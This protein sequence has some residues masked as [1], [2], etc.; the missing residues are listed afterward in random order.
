MTTEE[1]SQTE[2]NLNSMPNPYNTSI[3]GWLK[4]FLV[5]LLGLGV[6]GVAISWIRLKGANFDYDSPFGYYTV[7]F[8]TLISLVVICY[9][10]HAF[11]KVRCNA[12]FMGKAF[13]LVNLILDVVIVLFSFLTIHYI[14]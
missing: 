9:I 13:A 11:F 6:M 5:L 1:T 7:L 8:Q 12:V 14:K 3:H 2:V 10:V 4:V